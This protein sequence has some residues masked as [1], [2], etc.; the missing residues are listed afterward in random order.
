MFIAT[1]DQ[2]PNGTP[3]ISASINLI[4]NSDDSLASPECQYRWTLA[5]IDSIDIPNEIIYLDNTT[6]AVGDATIP[7]GNGGWQ[8]TTDFWGYNNSKTIGTAAATFQ[9]GFYYIELEV[10]DCECLEDTKEAKVVGW[11]WNGLEEVPLELN[12]FSIKT[13]QATK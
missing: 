10:Y 4:H 12:S 11:R 2:R 3:S 9:D 7:N 13:R 8:L 6:K 5:R 1:Q